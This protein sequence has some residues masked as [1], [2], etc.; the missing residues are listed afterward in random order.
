MN[1]SFEKAD[2]ED[3]DRLLGIGLR[4]PKLNAYYF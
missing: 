3:A 2:I 4:L 1:I